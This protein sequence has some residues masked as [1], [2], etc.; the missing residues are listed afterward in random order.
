MW[1]LL[2]AER[3]GQAQAA[4]WIRGGGSGPSRRARERL[5]LLPRRSD[6]AEGETRLARREGSQAAA[7]PG[8]APT[9]AG[10]EAAPCP[11]PPAPPRQGY[12]GKPADV[13]SEFLP[14]EDCY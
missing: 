4:T 13:A 3:T 2:G 5:R 11:H 1:A 12:E 8:H 7:R 14:F 10:A 6:A 9:A